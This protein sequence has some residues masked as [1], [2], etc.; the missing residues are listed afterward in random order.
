M[1]YVDV[2]CFRLTRSYV[3]LWAAVNA[4]MRLSEYSRLRKDRPMDTV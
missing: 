1:G 4:M 3:Q 2:E